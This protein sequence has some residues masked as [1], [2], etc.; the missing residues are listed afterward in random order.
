MA[1]RAARL[2][3]HIGSWLPHCS[4][5][6]WKE[7][8]ISACVSCCVYVAYP[9]EVHQSALLSFGV[10]SCAKRFSLSVAFSLVISTLQ[11]HQTRAHDARRR[12]RPRRPRGAYCRGNGGV[13]KAVTCCNR[14]SAEIR[15]SLAEKCQLQRACRLRSAVLLL[16]LEL[17]EQRCT[18]KSKVRSSFFKHSFKH[19]LH[20]Q[21][22]VVPQ[23]FLQLRRLQK[24]R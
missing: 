19:T 10:D 17:K 6:L 15:L 2:T 9:K 14:W 8:S 7:A 3:G 4:F 22:E 1:V 16:S 20:L 24:T 12:S 11:Q 18:C 13:A 23:E 21:E 5:G